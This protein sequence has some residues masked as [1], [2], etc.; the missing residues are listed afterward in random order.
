MTIVDVLPHLENCY[1][2]YRRFSLSIIA[3]SGGSL[4]A[5]VCGRFG[6]LAAGVT[7]GF[8][9]IMM[10]AGFDVPPNC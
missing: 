9:I 8:E 6:G 10:N 3:T 2:L 4:Y 5:G 1:A 7:M